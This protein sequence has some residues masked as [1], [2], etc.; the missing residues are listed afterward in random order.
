MIQSKD[1][2]VTT[3]EKF[4][5]KLIKRLIQTRMTWTQCGTSSSPEGA[6]KGAVNV[7]INIVSIRR[8]WQAG[9]TVKMSIKES[10]RVEESLVVKGELCEVENAVAVPQIEDGPKKRHTSRRKYKLP[11]NLMSEVEMR[12]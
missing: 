1:D 5:L 3:S 7:R 8:D 9:S 2:A 4:S 10:Q 6:R 11:A 12:R